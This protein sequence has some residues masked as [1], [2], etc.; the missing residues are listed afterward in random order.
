[1]SLLG[2]F[3]HGLSNTLSPPLCAF[4]DLHLLE[5]LLS[6]LNAY[7]SSLNLTAC[8]AS[9]SS[10]NLTACYLFILHNSGCIF[11]IIFSAAHDELSSLLDLHLDVNVA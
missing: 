3:L 8:F 2:L 5:K 4:Y 11:I 6:E 10:I 1:M 7:L 9:P